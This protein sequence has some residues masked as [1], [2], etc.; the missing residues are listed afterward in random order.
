VKGPNQEEKEG[1]RI[2]SDMIS[3]LRPDLLF[4]S[5]EESCK[6]L[7][8]AVGWHTNRMKEER[9]RAVCEKGEP[10]KSNRRIFLLS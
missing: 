9:R 2:E 3:R 1:T 8:P 6:R 7:E 5:V 4:E 10:W